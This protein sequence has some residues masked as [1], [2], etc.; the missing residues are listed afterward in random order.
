MADFA[1][2]HPNI[3][4][5]L[6]VDRNSALE[7]AVAKR[8]LDIALVFAPEASAD[9]VRLGQAP[10]MWI[11]SHDFRWEP[12]NELS[13]LL[14]EHPCMFRQAALQALDAAAIRW[15]VAVTSPSLGGIWAAAVAGMGATV[16]TGVA[17]PAGLVDIGTRFGLPGLPE[18]GIRILESDRKSNA[19]RSRLRS[20]LRDVIAAAARTQRFEPQW[21]G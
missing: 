15:R 18:V 2:T 16:R 19:A 7:R 8:E 1:R 4:V 20:V 13:L 17:L 5:E 21:P 12:G 10:M 11:A 3:Q 14:L 9:G 6:Q